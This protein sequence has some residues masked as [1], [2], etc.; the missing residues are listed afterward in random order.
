MNKSNTI[1]AVVAV[2]AIVF[3]GWFAYKQGYQ[4]GLS[5]NEQDVEFDLP[6]IR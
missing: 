5:E 1:I 2:I 3:M 6:G 4:K